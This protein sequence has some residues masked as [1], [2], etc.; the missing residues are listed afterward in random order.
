MQ[1]E[2]CSLG[3]CQLGACITGQPHI[4]R[5]AAGCHQVPAHR[6]SG[7]PPAPPAHRALQQ[8]RGAVCSSNSL[9]ATLCRISA[10]LGCK[11]L[12][13]A[14]S[15]LQ[16]YLCSTATPAESTGSSPTAFL[17]QPAAAQRHQQISPVELWPGISSSNALARCRCPWGC[18][19]CPGGGPS[20]GF[21]V[22]GT[23]MR[24]ACRTGFRGR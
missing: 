7:M 19:E 6:V 11:A 5:T 12:R 15:A 14:H 16:R 17:Q 22:I 23:S 4:G 3:K 13:M 8:R 1:G 20:K 24:E 2:N 10:T 9:P 21:S 18:L